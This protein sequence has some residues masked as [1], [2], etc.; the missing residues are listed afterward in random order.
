MQLVSLNV[1]RPRAVEWQGRTVT[2]AI[3]KQPMAGPVLLR[4]LNFDDDNQ[5]DLTVHGGTY[6]AVYA[7][8][9]EHYPYWRQQLPD[10]ELPWG[11][12]GE[13]LTTAG[14][15]ED[16]VWIGDRLR[17][18]EAELVVSEPR[19]PC[20]KL[21]LKFGRADMVKRFL[22]SRRC[23]F[24]FAVAREGVVRAGDTIERMDRG[25]GGVTVTEVLNA[26]A[27]ERD[28]PTLLRRVLQATA[29]S[30]IWR[31]FFEGRLG[32]SR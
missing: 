27:L 4:T 12:F 19:V 7:Y 15:L 9:S 16:D 13:N 25:E 30:P 10:T 21:G 24:Y 11:M 22:A 3:F 14:L 26:Y 17:V 2:T 1:G 8:P 31:E 6:K 28:N 20:Y 23:G 29:L 18:G 32:R 5:A